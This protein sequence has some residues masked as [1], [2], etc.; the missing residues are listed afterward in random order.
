MRATLKYLLA[1]AIAVFVA[2]AVGCG[3]SGDD[4]GSTSST[5]VAIS[6]PAFIKQGGEICDKADARQA[7]DY[8]DFLKENGKDESKA[9]E[10]EVVREVGLPA[11]ELE[12]EELREIGAPS[13]DEEEVSAI[14]DEVEAAIRQSEKEPLNVY[15]AGK[16]PFTAPEGKAAKYG[17]KQCGFT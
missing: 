17:L 13:G 10:E 3:S 9:R 2:F 6:K 5:A 7:A 11:I 12:V 15:D 14:L 8:K 16:N 1:A 4:S